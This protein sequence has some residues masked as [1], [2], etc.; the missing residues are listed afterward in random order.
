MMLDKGGYME[1]YVLGDMEQQFA[2]ILWEKAPITTR[3]IIDIGAKEFN[4]KRTT[5]YTMLKRLCDRGIF[6]NEKGTVM[7]VMSQEE[8]FANK[9]AFFLEE[10]FDGSLP[11][12][13]TAFSRR[14]R[15]SDKEI[16]AIER[17]IDEHKEG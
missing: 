4:W 1:K 13:L 7:V 2:K 16:K 3:E 6:T 17:L 14:K 11:R 12:F 10:S 5:T 8:F 9:S 15:L